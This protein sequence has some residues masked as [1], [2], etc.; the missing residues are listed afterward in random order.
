MV[1]S[2]EMY[3]S[4]ADDKSLNSSISLMTRILRDN[5]DQYVDNF[6]ISIEPFEFHF[7]SEVYLQFLMLLNSVIV[8][9]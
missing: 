1:F 4:K 6:P 5:G 2:L 7:E 3:K 8:N 9:S